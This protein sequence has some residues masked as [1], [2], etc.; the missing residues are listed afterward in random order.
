[1]RYDWIDDILAVVE[2]GS[3]A[4]AAAKRHVT[5]SAFTRRVKAIEESM[6]APLFDRS[7][8]PVTVLP[9]I[10]ALETELRELRAAERA[11]Q[12]KLRATGHT[13]HGDIS[14]VC[15]HSLTTTI[16]ASLVQ[17]IRKQY[18][19]AVKMFTG[20]QDECLLQLISNSVDFAMTYDIP[21]DAQAAIEPE[22]PSGF[23]AQIIATDVLIP[24]SSPAFRSMWDRGELPFISYPADVFLG[25]VF[26]TRIM[27]QVSSQVTLVP[28]A[29]TALT[30][31]MHHMV[32]SEIGCAW[33]PRSLCDEDLKHGALV[34]LEDCL[35][36][37][38]LNIV[39]TRHATRRHA[40]LDAIWTEVTQTPFTFDTCFALR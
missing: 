37:Q 36:V 34:T 6:N 13:E 4:S 7:K 17:F 20:N 21:L 23:Q 32:R 22:P 9:H 5:Q 2:T 18:D 14:F 38:P 1:M 25:K 40:V 26:S 28:M 33:L 11:I 10:K 8:K 12:S 27:P 15:Q 19:T 30:I 3:L 24:V 39:L 16:A 31:A 29:E 35:P